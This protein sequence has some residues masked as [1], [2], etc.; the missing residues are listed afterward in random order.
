MKVRY[1]QLAMLLAQSSEGGQLLII[2]KGPR[3]MVPNP[4]NM[5]S[6]KRNAAN[7]DR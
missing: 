3:D 2:I 5:R 7:V 4:L 6:L 1:I